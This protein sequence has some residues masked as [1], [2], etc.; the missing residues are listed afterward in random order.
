MKQTHFCSATSSLPRTSS[1]PLILQRL[2]SPLLLLPSSLL[3]LIASHLEVVS[4]L[5]LHRCSSVLNHLRADD[6]YMTAAWRWAVLRLSLDR[7]LPEW[8]L[9]H[10]QCI[11]DDGKTLIPASVWQAALPA[12][13]AVVAS[14]RCDERNRMYEWFQRRAN[15]VRQEQPTVW[16]TATRAAHDSW[17][18]VVDEDNLE[19]SAEVRRVEVLRDFDWWQLTAEAIPFSYDRDVRC[20]LVLRACPHL[21]HLALHLDSGGVD[22]HSCQPLSNADSFALVPQ[23]RSLRLEEECYDLMVADLICDFR[24]MLDSLPH[25]HTLSCM[26][27]MHLGIPQL[28]DIASHSTLENVHIRDSGACMAEAVWI[29]HRMLFPICVEDDRKRMHEAALS[30]NTLSGDIEE[31]DTVALEAAVNDTEFAPDKQ[32]NGDEQESK[33]LTIPREEVQRIRA[34]FTRTQPSQRSCE[35]R[36]ALAEWLHRRLRRGKLRADDNHRLPKSL[37]LR[38]RMHVA[39]LRSML[40]RQL[41][42]LASVSAVSEQSQ[43]E[44]DRPR[45]RARIEG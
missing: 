28:L 43:P 27:I 31:E 25:L 3:A 22:E 7:K 21:Q 19:Q 11:K 40:R 32:L 26:D 5:R 14:V 2:S 33:E 10:E 34:A 1:C 39:L 16:I 37:L 4:L 29:G 13:Q 45:K 24:A 12:W 42:E 17:K 9:P 23:L 6:A 41:S 15:A 38:Y 30:Y 44:L 35:V 18:V 36:L 8:T 20:R